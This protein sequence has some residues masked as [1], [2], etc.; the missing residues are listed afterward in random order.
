M[1]RGARENA[2]VRRDITE[3]LFSLL[4]KKEFSAITVTDL[5]T[6]AKVARASYYRNFEVKEAIVEGY[7]N[8]VYMEIRGESEIHIEDFFSYNAIV[9]RVEHALTCLLQKKSY[10]LAL[11]KN[12]FGSMILNVL[13]SYAEDAEGDMPNNS[14]E[15]YKL[16]FV[17]GATFN[18]LIKWLESG[19]VESPLEMAKACA[20]FLR[21]DIVTKDML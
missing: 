2:R 12:G 16:Y 20:S 10:I 13:N 8:S 11:Y 9:E 7:M 4:K 15:R 5:I 17:T 19:A 6:E 1:S 14:I 21:G 3:A 18:I